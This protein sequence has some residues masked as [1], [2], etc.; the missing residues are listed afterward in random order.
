ML[1]SEIKKW[2]KQHGYSIVKEKEN[3][4]FAYYWSK[5]DDSSISGVAYSVSK[6][7]TAIFNHITNNAWIEHQKEYKEKQELKH[8]DVSNYS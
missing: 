4:S 6:V 3:D 8:F 1:I 2:A 5:N 7:A